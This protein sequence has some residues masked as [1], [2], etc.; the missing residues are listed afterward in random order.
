MAG[1]RSTLRGALAGWR[2]HSTEHG[3]MLIMQVAGSAE[4][5]SSKQF[6]KVEIALNDRQLRSLTRDLMRA[7]SERGIQLWAERRWWQMLRPSA[8]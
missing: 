6:D 4:D 1:T 3:C 8:D 7:S 5:F 2:R